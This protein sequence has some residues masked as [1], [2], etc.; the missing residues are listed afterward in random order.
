MLM[1]KLTLPAKAGKAV[2]TQ[3]RATTGIKIFGFISDLRESKWT[4][5]RRIAGIVEIKGFANSGPRVPASGKRRQ[6][7]PPGRCI[8]L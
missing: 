1:P 4:G 6:A 2:N 3:H 5:G 8:T 7:Y